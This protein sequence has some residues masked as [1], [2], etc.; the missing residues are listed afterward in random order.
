MFQN[1]DV[2]ET[3]GLPWS[4]MGLEMFVVRETFSLG[5]KGTRQQRNEVGRTN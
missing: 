5:Q 3:G 2:I 4:M 1:I